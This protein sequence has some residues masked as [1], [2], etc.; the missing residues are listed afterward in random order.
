MTPDTP[1]RQK[2]LS[3]IFA[4]LMAIVVVAVVIIAWRSIQRPLN[5]SRVP[6]LWW[7]FGVGG[8]TA[9]AGIAVALKR[10][11]WVS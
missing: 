9:G 6:D 3:A 5:P 8:L 2:Q 4:A 7:K 10:P 1:S 11:Q